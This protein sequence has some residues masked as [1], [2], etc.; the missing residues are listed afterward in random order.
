MKNK[1]KFSPGFSLVELMVSLVAGLI[2]I[3][4]VGAFMMS[5]FRSNTDFVA[6]TRLTQELRSTIDFISKD[7]RRA[8]YDES[9]MDYLALPDPLPVGAKKTSDFA[10]IRMIDVLPAGTPDN[11]VDDEC[12]IYAYDRAPG[13]PGLVNLDN[14]EI[15]GIRRVVN[16][17]GVG[18]IEVADSSTP[19]TPIA[20][21]CNG[22]QANYTSYPAACNLTSGWCALSDPRIINI[23]AFTL[24]IA[25]YE[26]IPGGGLVAPLQIRDVVV[27]LQG[28]LIGDTDVSRGVD[29]S[30]RIRADCLK[31]N[32]NSIP[33][34]LTPDCN[35]APAQTG[36]H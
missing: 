6:A 21:A 4:A 7:L 27:H 3:G 24:N 5:S 1:I 10:P 26:N 22:A 12:V 33:V 23:S 14:G 31:T 18:V 19:T 20:P 34:D 35:Q 8:G 17:N 11:I 36:T 2:V 29:S 16:A 25:G 15:R 30:V 28:N 32:P 9:A 13:E